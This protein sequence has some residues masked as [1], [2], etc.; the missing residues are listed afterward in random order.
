MAVNGASYNCGPVSHAMY[1]AGE[2]RLTLVWTPDSTRLVFNY[3]AT[4]DKLYGRSPYFHTTYWVVDAEGVQLKKLVEANPGHISR[5]GHHA[6]VSPDGRRLVYASCEYPTGHGRRFGEHPERGK[7]NYEIVVMKM[8]G[9]EQRRLTRND[10]W[11]TIQSGPLMAT[12]LLSYRR[13]L[14]R[15]CMTI[16]IIWNF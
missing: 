10:P 12:T 15:A 5:Y 2:D 6:D 8:N 7:Y 16:R 1:T 4:L 9:T 11:T 3:F 14:V 13:V